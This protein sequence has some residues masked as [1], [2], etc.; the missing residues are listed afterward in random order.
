VSLSNTR[1]F[2]LESGTSQPIH[3]PEVP[4]L[5]AFWRRVRVRAKGG[6]RLREVNRRGGGSGLYTN[7]YTPF[8][9][10]IHL[11]YTIHG[12]WSDPHA[13]PPWESR[14]GGRAGP[15]AES[16]SAQALAKAKARSSHQC[17]AKRYC[18][19]MTSCEEAKF[20][21]TRCGLPRLDGDGDGLPC[22]ALCK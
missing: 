9:I 14:H 1:V 6:Y 10:P 20:Y 19:E 17:G 16:K 22:E 5:W 3:R 15:P 13:I 18:K 12:L 4:S 8:K 21:L 2:G 7:S 11:L